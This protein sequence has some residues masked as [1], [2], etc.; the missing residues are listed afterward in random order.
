MAATCIA[1]LAGTAFAQ[2]RDPAGPAHDGFGPPAWRGSPMGPRFGRGHDALP[3]EVLD[4]LDLTAAQRAKVSS[5]R[6]EAERSGIRLEADLR[7]A[8]L[9]LRKLLE[10]DSPDPR[11][12]EE[13][14][15]RVGELH[16]QMRKTRVAAWLAVRSTLTAEQRAKLRTLARTPRS[17]RDGRQGSQRT[18]AD[19][20]H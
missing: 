13:A 6:D 15:E 17:D 19:R 3:M 18:P 20:S 2:G 8:E 12:V 14:I 11:E 1:L 7:I 4:Q 9:D 5:L 16:T 10:A